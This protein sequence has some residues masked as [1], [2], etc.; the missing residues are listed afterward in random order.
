[1]IMKSQLL[2]LHKILLTMGMLLPA[3]NP[4]ASTELNSSCFKTGLLATTGIFNWNLEMV[5]LRFLM[6]ALFL[7]FIPNI[8]AKANESSKNPNHL[9]EL[10]TFLEGAPNGGMKFHRKNKNLF[11]EYCPDNTC[12]EIRAA[13]KVDKYLFLSISLMYYKY[14]SKYIYLEPWNDKSLIYTTQFFL[15]NKIISCHHFNDEELATCVLS[16]AGKKY[17]LSV[18]FARYDGNSR[19]VK[20][21]Y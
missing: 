17:A 14:T 11:L 13:K 12:E 16:W 5:S 20:K 18:Y 2:S 7:L 9:D 10:M 1:M 3:R 21:L 6:G 15:K 19:V 4:A 8:E